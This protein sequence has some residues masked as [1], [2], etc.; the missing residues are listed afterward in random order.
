MITKLFKILIPL[1]IYAFGREFIATLQMVSFADVFQKIFF[2]ALGGGFLFTTIF[3]KTHGYLA[4]LAHELTH[5]VLGVL[6]FNKP[7]ALNVEAN[8]GGY[9]AYQ[10]KQNILSVL[11]PYF[12][13]LLTVFIFPIYFILASSGAEVYFGLLGATLGFSFSIAIRQGK[14]HQP[15]LHVFGITWSYLIILFFQILIWGLLISFVIGR[16]PMLV[17]FVKMSTDHIIELYEI[18][19]VLVMM[20]LDMIK[21]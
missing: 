14:P 8:S 15:D 9:F 17:S 20:G 11:S 7:I 4:I 12:F 10:G 16:I 21:G 5:N 18:A 3:V 13:P 1:L 19:K 2:I 6:T